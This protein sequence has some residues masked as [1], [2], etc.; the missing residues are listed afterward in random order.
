MLFHKDVYRP[1]ATPDN[2]PFSVQSTG[3]YK[4]QHPFRSNDGI[5]SFVQL[6]WCIRGQ[7]IVEFAGR[8]RILGRNQIALY[9]PNMRHYWYTDRHDWDFYWLTIYGP[10][11]AS[12]VAA[13]GL[14]A[15]VYNAGPAPVVLFQ[16]LRRLV[17]Q[18]SRQAELRACATAF[19]IL[20][21]AADSQ[22]DKTDETMNTVVQR[23]HK[24]YDSSEL[25]IKTLIAPLN[26]GR[27]AF[28]KRFR[29]ATGMSPGKYL[30][31]LR[32][33]KALALLK[34]TNFPIAAISR[35]C[36]Y[37]NVQYFSRVIRHVTDRSP[38]QFR[39]YTNR[40]RNHSQ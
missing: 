35:Q 9:Y 39:K 2:L 33:Q 37:T 6:F 24:Q 20:T 7:G 40:H 17:G 12:F 22:A 25:N 16:T 26:T 8:R 30:K 11:A 27:I 36:G 21:R 38:F 3:F 23:M 28:F 14:E 15:D 18:T 13:L 34:N 29:T 4:I 31:R 19:M 1:A 32:V 5:T 10:F